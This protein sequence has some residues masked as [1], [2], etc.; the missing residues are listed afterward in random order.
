MI[1]HEEVTYH[2]GVETFKGFLAYR[3]EA[4]DQ[5]RP[6]VLIAPT[7]MGRDEF[8][9]QKARALAELGYIGF[10]LD[11]YG[12]GKV[13]KDADEAMS[14]MAPLFADRALLQARMKAA[15]G[16]LR[17]IDLVDAGRIGVI[18]FCFG[19]LASIELLRSGASIKGA[20]SFHGVLGSHRDNIQAKTVPIATPVHGA[21]LVLHGYH[22]PL[23]SQADILH[24]EKE[25]TD[26]QVDWQFNT[27]GLA[28]HS[29]T[30]PNQHDKE[31]GLYFE[32]KANARSWS[33][34]KRFFEE[35]FA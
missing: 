3:E 27:Y 33:A 32:P 35:I 10:A 4:P 1:H 14:L 2:I 11:P 22:D 23:V 26:A 17:Q 8:A 31:S 15:L 34:M 30:T 16:A 7:W 28:G 5:K 18:G 9:C 29:F 21:L 19:G 25:M 24:L 12:N 20:V 13:A 6:A